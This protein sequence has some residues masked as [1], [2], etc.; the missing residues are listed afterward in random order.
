MARILLV[1]DGADLRTT[2]KESLIESLHKVDEAANVESAKAALDVN[3]Y[4][5]LLVDMRMPPS[6]S[7][8][9]V[10]EKAGLQVIDYAAKKKPKPVCIVMTAYGSVGNM[11]EAIQRGAWDYVDKPL[12]HMGN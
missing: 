1:E 11:F 12:A 7:S 5:I 6:G 9:N 2:V 4:D 8:R 10:E 3:S